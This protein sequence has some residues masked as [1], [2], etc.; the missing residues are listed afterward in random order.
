MILFFKSHLRKI[1]ILEVM[2]YSRKKILNIFFLFVLSIFIFQN[3]DNKKKIAWSKSKI[4]SFSDSDNVLRWL[5][6]HH[7]KPEKKIITVC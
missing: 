5:K 7:E 2:W 4:I 6:Q 1:I 3:F